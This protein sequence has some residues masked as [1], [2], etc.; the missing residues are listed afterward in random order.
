MISLIMTL[1]IYK[2]CKTVYFPLQKKTEWTVFEVPGT[3]I[4][5]PITSRHSLYIVTINRPWGPHFTSGCTKLSHIKTLCWRNNNNAYLI[6]V[7]GLQKQVSPSAIMSRLYNNN[8]GIC[9]IFTF[10]SAAQLNNIKKQQMPFVSRST[11]VFSPAKMHI[12]LM[13]QAQRSMMIVGRLVEMFCTTTC[14]GTHAHRQ[15]FLTH[16]ST[17]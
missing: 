14:N 6:L 7:N 11:I 5:T 16:K 4:H 9:N 10:Y 13:V 17:W 3:Q 1:F 2:R 12:T 8:S 15:T